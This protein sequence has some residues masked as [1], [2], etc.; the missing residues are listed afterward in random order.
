MKFPQIAAPLGR[1]FAAPACSPAPPRPRR[2]LHAPRL[3]ARLRRPRPRARSRRPRRLPREGPR[4]GGQG[5][6]QGCPG[7]IKVVNTTWFSIWVLSSAKMVSAAAQL[8]ISGNLGWRF[9]CRKTPTQ[10]VTKFMGAM[11]YKK[12]PS[13]GFHSLIQV[14]FL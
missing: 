3:R 8:K 6:T 10:C 12:G 7:A 9:N 2:L 13:F 14:A 11:Y 5:E 4:R 1:L